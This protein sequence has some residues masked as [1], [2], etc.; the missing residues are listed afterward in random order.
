MLCAGLTTLAIFAASAGATVVYE[1]DNGDHN[2]PDPAGVPVSQDKNVDGSFEAG[3]YQAAD[4]FTVP[5]G[6]YWRVREVN[7][8]GYYNGRSYEDGRYYRWT[9]AGPA[10]SVDVYFYKDNGGTPSGSAPIA[11]RIARAYTNTS[12]E[13]PTSNPRGDGPGGVIHAGADFDI[14]LG[15]PVNLPSGTYWVSVWARQDYSTHGLWGW[16]S[17]T[18]HTDRGAKAMVYATTGCPISGWQSADSCFTRAG[19]DLAFRLNGEFMDFL[20]YRTL[21]DGKGTVTSSGGSGSGNFNCGPDDCR[22][23]PTGKRFARGFQVTFTARASTSGPNS[24][25]AGWDGCDHPSGTTCVM[26]MSGHTKKLTAQFDLASSLTIRKTGASDGSVSS[27]PAKVNCPVGVCKTQPYLYKFSLGSEVWLVAHNSPSH[28]NSIFVGWTGCDHPWGSACLMDMNQQGT[29]QVYAEFEPAS[30]LIIRKLGAGDGTI[31]STPAKVNCQVGR[32]KSQPYQY[33]FRTGTKATLK[34]APRTNPTSTFGGWTGC[35][36][37]AGLTCVMD[38]N[39][40]QGAKK[41]YA[42]FN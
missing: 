32:C 11:S 16:Q 38:M 26:D 34:A 2:A 39:N 35:D 19:P 1:N 20:T 14:Q 28:P 17:L 22:S 9:A 18:T 40:E 3:E 5:A 21:G 7:V 42:T 25:F 12:K 10:Q 24:V 27:D 30:A 13:N 37:P 31:T 6:G 33:K 36:H 4:D 23:Q 41:V 29:K 15:D 8:R